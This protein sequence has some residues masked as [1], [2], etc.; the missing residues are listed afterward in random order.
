MSDALLR[1]MAIFLTIVSVGILLVSTVLLSMAPASTINW[2]HNEVRSIV[3]LG[4][5][6]VGVVIVERRPRQRIGWLWIF[7]GVFMGFITLGHGI[8]YSNGAQPGEYSS[9]EFF[10]L[11]FTEPAQLFTLILPILLM[12]WFPDGQLTS[13]RWR[14]LPPPSVCRKRNSVLAAV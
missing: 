8:Y 12:L 1:Y 10:L 4:A 6:I 14:A 5:P 7:Y 3:T 11:W 2:L 13:R 9:L